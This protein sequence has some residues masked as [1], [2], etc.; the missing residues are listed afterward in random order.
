[1]KEK[2]KSIKWEIMAVVLLLTLAVTGTMSF[3]LLSIQTKSITNEVELR[4][5]SL[6]RNIANNIA[7][8]LLIKHELEAAKILKDAMKNRGIMYAMVVDGNNR[9]LAHNDMTQVKKEYQP[10]GNKSGITPGK[11]TVYQA[12]NGGKIIEFTSAVIAKNKV[13]IGVVH[14]GVSHDVIQNA[15]R[16]TYYSIMAVIVL[17]VILS[18][19]GAFFLSTA[20]TKPI[21]ILAEGAKIA[22]TGDLSHKIEIKKRN[23]LGL[24]ADTFN[25]MTEGLK[26]AQEAALER[27]ALE[28]ELE[29]AWQIQDALLPKTFPD[30][31]KYEAAAFYK[32]AKEIG[33]DYYDVIPLGSGRFGIVMADV[34]GKGIP[35][36][37][38][39]TMLS[40][41]LNIEARAAADPV[42]VISRLNSGLQARISGSMFATVF[43]GVLDVSKN[44][45]EMVSAG[46]HEMLIYRKKEAAVEAVCPKGAA[47]GILQ[48]GDFETRLEKKAVSI[49][50]GDKLLLFTDGIS[51]A[52]AKTGGRYGME[53]VEQS[54]RNYG[55]QRCSP[56]LDG[57]LSEVH[58]FTGGQEQSDDIAVLA[59]GRTV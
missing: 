41:V 58:Q 12:K 9:I 40:S 57:L 49:K 28:K 50:A 7:D 13:K 39:M 3:L 14:T 33:G 51:E 29:I 35:A 10:P 8:F 37:L 47:I 31:G 2:L 36:A 17:A 55:K 43:Y 44:L 27:R 34:S 38:I 1:M 59:I 24:L 4:G 30:M 56:M 54:L 46:H 22:G 45:I 52:R 16:K 11:N 32:P 23:E 15:L 20:I 21:N 26:K 25:V 48:G 42:S 6:T 18:V 19:S 5:V 53:R